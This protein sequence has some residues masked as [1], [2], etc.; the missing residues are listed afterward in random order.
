[1]RCAPGRRSRVSASAWLP[2]RSDGGPARGRRPPRGGGGSTPWSAWWRTTARAS[3]RRTAS[4]SSTPSSPRS[5]PERARDSASPT[6]RASPRSSGGASSSPSRTVRAPS[7]CCGSRRA[8]ASPAARRAPSRAAGACE[9]GCAATAP[10]CGARAGRGI[11]TSRAAG[12]WPIG[13][14]GTGVAPTPLRGPR[15]MG[16]KRDQAGRRRGGMTLIEIMVV[17]AI[18]AVL[19]GV[20]IPNIAEWSRHMR[21]KDGAR[22]IGDLLLLA[23][24]EAIRT[25]RRQVV[26]F[27]PPGS[28]DPALNPIE[29]NGTWVPVLVLD[30]GPPATSNCV[31]DAGEDVEGLR[32][33]DGLSWGVSVATG[34]VPTDSGAGPFA[35]APWD[36]GT[37]ADGG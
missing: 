23:R 10:G 13:R 4:A 29:A 11:G 24:T 2:P 9:A 26:F 34:P 7:S 16:R 25:G 30:D 14:H 36:G 20:A 37:F 1:M 5:R 31:I 22:S 19:L 12:G 35:P 21:L 15:T 33:L 3:P 27:G 32:P 8:P 18:L 6:R 28:L 17:L